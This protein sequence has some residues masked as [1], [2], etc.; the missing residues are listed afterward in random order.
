MKSVEPARGW[1]PTYRQELILRAALCRGEEVLSAW[2][3]LK[4]GDHLSPLDGGSARLLPLLYHNLR[5]H[6]VEEPAAEAL[7]EEY[8]RTWCD[9]QLLFESAAGIVRSFRAAGIE[10]MLLKGAA[11]ASHF[12][13]DSGLR[14]MSDVD[15]LVRHE[16]AAAA[17]KLLGESGWNSNYRS[18]QALIPYEQAVEF[19]DGR[20]GRCDL[21]WRILLDGRQ[22]VG[23]ED[24]WEA[25]VPVELEAT[26]TRA[27]NPADQLLHV[28]VHG[29]EWNDMP[30]VRWVADAAMIIRAAQSEIDWARLIEQTQKRRLMLPMKDTLGYLC[31]L[32]GD[33][34]PDGVV[35]AVRGTPATPTERALYRIRSGPA[36]PLKRILVAHYWFNSWQLA[37]APSR[38]RKL[39]D[40]LDYI[41]CLWDAEHLWQAPFYLAYKTMRGVAQIL[42][43]PS[44]G[45]PEPGPIN[46]HRIELND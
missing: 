17:V 30:P 21:H 11:L 42:L 44:S 31:D 33:A 3:R 20:G 24:F 34:V 29:A 7:K 35:N 2:R 25:S 45:K 32:L 4:E 43:R 39:L 16:K 36:K 10:T 41:K 23:D 13:G 14:P 22:D 27:L 28:C 37:R 8:V 18:P 38:R 6:G 26:P 5:L 46:P 15:I 12:Y 19:R 1:R 40:F 9:N